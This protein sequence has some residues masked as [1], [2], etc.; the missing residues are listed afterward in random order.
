M[1]PLIVSVVSAALI[2]GTATL[3]AVTVWNETG[4]AGDALITNQQ[5]AGSGSLTEISGTLPT[6]GDVDIYLITIPAPGLFSARLVGDETTDPDLWLF[7]STGKG[8]VHNDI[9]SGS[10][11]WLT[12]AFVVTAGDYYLAITNDGAVA[13]SSGGPIWAAPHN[14]VGARAPDGAGAAQTFT[15]WG[16]PMLNNGSAYTIHLEGAEFSTIPE[17]SAVALFAVGSLLASRRR[18]TRWN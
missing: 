17:P 12:A 3:S 15:N 9:V 16:G 1:N 8:V 4:D 10:Y 2:A 13:L 6:D 5:T 18:R 11:T 7:D 14:F